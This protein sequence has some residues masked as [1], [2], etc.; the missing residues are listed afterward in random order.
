MCL[1]PARQMRHRFD[2]TRAV[3]IVAAILLVPASVFAQTGDLPTARN[4]NSLLILV[5]GLTNG[6]I[7]GGICS[8]GVG[9]FCSPVLTGFNVHT[10]ADDADGL[11]Q[12][13]ILL[14]GFPINAGNPSLIT[15]TLGG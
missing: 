2:A 11:G 5:P 13:R 9:V 6:G 10:S 3:V 15:G 14:D 8:G 12:G 7:T 4:A 1:G